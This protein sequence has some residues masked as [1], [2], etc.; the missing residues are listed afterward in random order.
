MAEQKGT[1]RDSRYTLVI[2]DDV[3][4]ARVGN[5][6]ILEAKGSRFCLMLTRG[7]LTS[8]A[9]MGFSLACFRLKVT[10]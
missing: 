2:C 9:T 4:A 8:P 7:L 10:R 6:P 3:L 1:G 5:D